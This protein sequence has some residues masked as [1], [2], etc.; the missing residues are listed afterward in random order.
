MA[1]SFI[2]LFDDGTVIQNSVTLLKNNG[3]SFN[4]KPQFDG[5]LLR[6][7]LNIVDK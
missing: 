1:R 5:Q 6:D 4:L 2:I 7:R 3:Y